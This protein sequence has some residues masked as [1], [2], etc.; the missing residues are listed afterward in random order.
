M[1]VHLSYLNCG[2]VPSFRHK[3]S[4]KIQEKNKIAK[5]MSDLVF[6]CTPQR[7]KSWTHYKTLPYNIISSFAEK[8]A[9]AVCSEQ[10]GTPKVSH[11][12]AF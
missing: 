5:E 1:L 7:F 3:G 10:T 2:Y 4:Q 9:M 6:Y 8:K 12:L 11:R